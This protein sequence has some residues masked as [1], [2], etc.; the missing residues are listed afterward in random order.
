MSMVAGNDS[1]FAVTVGLGVTGI[2]AE[3]VNGLLEPIKCPHEFQCNFYE[4]W[5]NPSRRTTLDA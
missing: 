4:H 1:H 3:D 5:I 2:E